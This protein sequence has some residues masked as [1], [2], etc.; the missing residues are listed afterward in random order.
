MGKQSSC[1]TGA[2]SGNVL[3][4][5]GLCAI[6]RFV[7]EREMSFELR[8]S[9]CEPRAWSVRRRALSYQFDP[10]V[11]TP[12]FRHPNKGIQIFEEALMQQR[13][14]YNQAAPGAYKA[15]LG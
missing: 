5:T 9:S 15:M 11:R 4:E 13:L 1:I 14:N 7:P 12:G 8:G 3:E 2:R 6:W 10:A